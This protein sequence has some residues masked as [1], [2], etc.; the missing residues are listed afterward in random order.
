MLDIWIIRRK[1]AV[2]SPAAECFLP[3]INLWTDDKDNLCG[4]KHR[5]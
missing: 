2:L 5:P 3:L 4:I 1:D